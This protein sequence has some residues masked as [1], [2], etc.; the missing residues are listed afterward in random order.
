MITKESNMIYN[1]IS[2][3]KHTISYKRVLYRKQ[4]HKILFF[5]SRLTKNNSVFRIQKLEPFCSKRIHCLEKILTRYHTMYTVYRV[6]I[7]V[8]QLI[9]TNI[10]Q[11]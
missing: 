3:F 2:I 6:I 10:G 1:I 9:D 7:K 8:M 5:S 11:E 4:R